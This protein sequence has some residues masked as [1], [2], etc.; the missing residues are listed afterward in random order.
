[1]SGY[2]R[3]QAE[4]DRAFEQADRNR[5]MSREVAIQIQPVPTAPLT[6]EELNLFGTG[7]GFTRMIG[8]NELRRDFPDDPLVKFFD[9]D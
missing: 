7:M 8:V 1:M 4:I 6:E 9:K 5:G 2:V 3:S